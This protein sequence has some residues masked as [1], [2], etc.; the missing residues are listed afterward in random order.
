MALL[1][2]SPFALDFPLF[3]HPRSFFDSPFDAYF[4]REFARTSK[5]LS[6]LERQATKEFD[7]LFGQLNV[8]NNNK[9]ELEI[10]VPEPVA[11]PQNLS[12]EVKNGMLCVSA[13]KSS[14]GYSSHFTYQTTLPENV[15]AD[16]IQAHW[17]NETKTLKFILPSKPE[18]EQKLIQIP[19]KISQ[20]Q[21]Q[22]A[23]ESKQE[24]EEEKTQ[25]ETEHHE[26]DQH[27]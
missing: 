23:L 14:D 9:G 22:I 5:M 4:D 12:I 26:Q 15:E 19:V 8:L 2:G 13:K 10:H 11:D 27:A 6:K 7:E 1:L 16:H 20:D 24:M 18:E 3:H 17:D 21:E 25:N